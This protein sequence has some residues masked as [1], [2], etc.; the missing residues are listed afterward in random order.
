M[1]ISAV[2]LT[3]NNEQNLGPCLRSLK[4]IDEIIVVDD[5]SQDNTKVIAKKYGA[6]FFLKKLN[7]N[8]AGQR[9]F[10][11]NKARNEWVIFIDSDEIVSPVLAKEIQTA[12]K[13]KDVAGYYLKRQDVF[14]NHVLKYGEIGKVRLLR[15][16]QKKAGQWQ[17]QVH[18]IWRIS[19]KTKPLNQPLYHQRDLSLEQF[20]ER[21]DK[22]SQIDAKSQLRENKV[23]SPWQLSKPLGKFLDN[24]VLKQGFRDGFAGLI[25]AWLM[26][27]YS[28][29]LRV[30]V[31]EQSIQK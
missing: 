7:S 21:L 8:W 24:F 9:N 22:Y 4:F 19:G 31:W 18:E 10:G 26:S 23:F 1:S 29:V 6:K 14:L 17:R 16:A 27:F 30:K 2:V 25:F 28:L 11:L 12:I 20:I 15:L 13:N 5:F 3:K